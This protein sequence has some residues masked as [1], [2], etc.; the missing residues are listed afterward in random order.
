MC[1]KSLGS[2]KEKVLLNGGEGASHVN[3]RVQTPEQLERVEC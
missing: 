1:R 2:Q 3:S